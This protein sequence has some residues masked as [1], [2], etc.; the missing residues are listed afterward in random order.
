E[1]P[2]RGHIRQHDQL[3]GGDC[4]DAVDDLGANHT[5]ASTNDSDQPRKHENTKSNHYQLL[6]RLPETEP[7]LPTT[8]ENGRHEGDGLSM[9]L[10]AVIDPERS[11]RRFPADAE[12]E[13]PSQL[14][15]VN[16]ARTRE[17]IAAVEEADSADAP[18]ERL[19][20]LRVQHDEAVAAE[21]KPVLV[22]RVVRLRRNV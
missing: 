21:R 12:A 4:E 11:E 17:D 16:R 20:Q 5:D 15:Q 19:A 14:G 6:K 7:P 13:R 8:L 9:N 22:E 10:E 18:S 1:V 3:A 2:G